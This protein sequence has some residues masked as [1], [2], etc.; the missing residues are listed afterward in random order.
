LTAAWITLAGVFLTSA[1]LAA[2]NVA[3]VSGAAALKLAPSAGA[4][5]DRSGHFLNLNIGGVALPTAGQDIS[6]ARP[7]MV[8]G[9]LTPGIRLELAHGRNFDAFGDLFSSPAT[10]SSAYLSGT[11]SS[12]GASFALSDNVSFSI[13][14]SSWGFGALGDDQ[15]SQFSRDLAERLGANVRGFG[16]TSA[17][18][19]WNFADWGGLA[20]TASRSS[21]N[22][23]LLG[24]VP[25][26]L[27]G[28]GAADTTSLGISARVGFGEGWVTTVAYS[29][30]V[31][32]IDLS[33][34][35]LIGNTDS[36][37]LQA[38]GVALAKQGLFGADALGIAVSRPSQVYGGSLG[39]ALA[40][41]QARESDVELGYVTSFLGGS[42]ALQA[43]AAYQVNAAG[44]QGQN[45]VAGVARAKLKF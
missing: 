37:S 35:H 45:A 40:N 26:S 34:N 42:L 18:L 6:S 25:G 4:V 29:G 2:S 21:G 1:A 16:T 36:V 17:I 41:S 9:D 19:N 7:N 5:L 10:L 30:G 44:A 22:A 13:G 43:N 12:V 11:S 32:Q 23:S 8:V 15:P 20:I 24:I 27:S 14:Q 38:F 28:V 31:S 3:P 39:A 33:R